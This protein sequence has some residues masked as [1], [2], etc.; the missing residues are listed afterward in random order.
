MATDV[1]VGDSEL[2]TLLVSPADGTTEVTLTAEAPDG[3][4]TPIVMTGGVLEPIEG[5]SDQQQL[6]TATTPVTYDQAGRWVLHYEVTG[7]GEGAEDLEVYVVASPV[8]GGPTW[9]P[10]RSRVADYVPWRT[11]TVAQS[12]G[13]E[14]EDT[15]Q[16]SFST[17]TRPPGDA[18]DRLIGNAVSRVL[19]RVGT[20]DATLHDAARA[21]AAVLA[22][23]WIERGWPEGDDSLQRATDLEKQGETLLTELVQANEA[24]T[25]EG[26]YGFDE[27][28]ALYSFPP[29]DCRWDNPSYW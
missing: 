8:A 9:A 7:T 23:A 6:W 14:S 3:T 12:T 11:L 26:E 5:S 22:A 20:L 21:V 24:A 1:G 16:G 4:S 27:V 29:A 15:Y 2:G 28:A 25:G 18:V 17:T 13:L 19:T 10:G